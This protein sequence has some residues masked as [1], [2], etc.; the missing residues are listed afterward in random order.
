MFNSIQGFQLSPQQ[1]RL[2][3]LQGN[4]PAYHAHCAILIEGNLNI[5][6]LKEGLQ[7]V[8]DRHEILRTSFQRP[9]GIKIP[10][11][12]IEDSVSVSLNEQNNI[13]EQDVDQLFQKVSQY[14]LDLEEP[15]LLKTTL[16]RLFPNQYVLLLSLPALCADTIALDHLVAEIARCYTFCAEGETLDDEPLQYADI[17]QWQN[18][19]LEIEQAEA[20][21]EYWQQQNFSRGKTLK[22]ASEK[23]SAEK[24]EFEP[25]SITVAI[26]SNVTEKIEAIAQSN[27]TTASAFFL[28]CWQILLGR[29]TAQADL[30]I[31]VGFDGR[32]YEELQD[33]IGLF[34]KYLPL[35]VHLAADFPFVQVLQQV[36]PS[37]Y[38]LS[39]WQDSYTWESISESNVQDEEPPFFPFCFDFEPEFGSYRAGEVC[40]SVYRKYACVDQ[41]K[42]KLRTVRRESSWIAEFHYDSNSFAR[43]DIQR[44]AA[45]FQTLLVSAS[46]NPDAAIGEL[47]ILSLKERQQ[48]LVAF[49]TTTA[50][51]P[52]DK[53]LH[54]LFEAQVERTPNAIAVVFE[55]Q[56]LTYRE[57]NTKANQLAHHLQKLGVGA[58]V[59]VGICVER[60][61]EMVIGLLGILKAGG[62]YVP[63]E[64]T[65]P[66]QRQTF[67]LADTKIPVLLTQQRFVADLPTQQTTAI[68][69]DTDWQLIGKEPINDPIS[70]TTTHNLAYVIYTSGSTGQPKGTMITHQ[71]VVNYLSWCTQAYAVE[72]GTG[73][74]V[75]SPL[76]F[77]LTVT[78][79]FSSLLVGRSVELLPA[80]QGLETLASA[81]RRRT[82]LSLVKITPA[83][84]ELLSQQLS[85]QEAAG[86]T[87]AFIIGGENLLARHI[88]FWQQH[89]PNTLLVNE[90]GPTETVVGCCVYYVPA[91]Q[92][93]SGSIPIGRAIANTQLYVLDRYGQPVP[94]GVT[95]ELYIGGAGLA[96][97]Y[98]NRPELT[99]EKF[100]PNPFSQQLGDRLYRT[101]DLARYRP[102]GTLEYLGRI[103]D[104]VKIRG[105][106]IEL[107]EVEAVL[108][109]VPGVRE[110][111]VM[112]REDIPGHQR[113]V[114]YLVWNQESSTSLSELRDFLRQKLPEYMLPSAFV[115]LDTLPL[116][117]NGKVDRK[118]LPAPDKERPNL[119][120]AYVAPRTPIEQV[121]AEIWIQVLGLEQVGVHDNFLEVG[122]DSILSI[123]VISRA[124]QAGLHLTPQQLFDYPTIAELATVAGTAATISSEQG[125]VIGSVP[126]TPIQHWFFEQ[127]L[128]DS[129]HWNQ[130]VLLEVS[131]T[132]NPEQLQK[133]VEHLLKHHDSLRLRFK[134][135]TGGWQQINSSP[136]GQ[137]PFTHLDLSARSLQEQQSA[138]AAT[139]AELQARLNLSEG[140]LLRVAWFNLGLHQPS[141][142][143]L[144]IHHLA[145]DGVSWR[146]LL[147]DFQTAYQHLSQGKPIQLPPKTTA[148]KQW[149]EQLREYANSDT[150]RQE[151]NY[152]LTIA[153]QPVKRLPIDFP[154]GA[155]TVATRRTTTF[156]LSATDTQAL[157]QEIPAAYRVQ[158]HEVLLT[159]LV[160]TFTQW[161]GTRSALLPRGDAKGE[162]SSASLSLLIDLE[163]HGREAIFD[164]VDLSRTVG[165]FTTIFPV[166]LDLGQTSNLGDVLRIIKEQLRCIP[167]RGLGYGVLRYLCSDQGISQK[168]QDLPQAE[169]SFN[170]LGQF[171]QLLSTA[172]LFRPAKESIDSTRSQRGNR[173][174]LIEVEGMV[175]GGQ[176]RLDWTY[177]QTLHH[178]DTVESLAQRMEAALRSLITQGQSGE[179]D[180]YTPSDFPDA[181]LTQAELDKV[182]EEI[183]LD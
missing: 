90:Y 164:H 124:K 4:S 11:Q 145:I 134:R 182:F 122:G 160:Q 30:I 49:N 27:Q 158:I 98:L 51:Y 64:P 20:G 141:R 180:R 114:A 15:P 157:L 45:Q 80:N 47:E 46:D 173:R 62:A 56:Q 125:L 99:A 154:G 58:E 171:D 153:E 28:T 32:N 57:L 139:T 10:I 118:V 181:E 117:L 156:T 91:D 40:F 130:A 63:I 22:L 96:R 75:H 69:L 178:P 143:L 52:K 137:V 147:E 84:L 162:R 161:M 131:Q 83:H 140:P 151:L 34:A 26:E 23:Q 31:G 108:S 149:A 60:S 25:Q 42:V 37:L 16:V 107:G 54:Q 120:S 81:L 7:Q 94:I 148:F 166:F 169:V 179:V 55:D 70:Q 144:I 24:F 123:Q 100:I 152:W 93:S 165:W 183:G 115:S 121:L 53:C 36:E 92:G 138:I 163:G 177:S 65:Y 17:A 5:A 19:L 135:S 109:Q 71:G 129:H 38:E 103:D 116:T 146:I 155:N 21:E 78:S 13:R 33:A 136:D 50:D 82:N 110:S 1:K 74:L 97:G 76:G 35:P 41:F 105:F 29:L 67:I 66:L 2:F 61:L 73:T 72:E 127:N 132:L 85:P 126:L 88:T 106:R 170:Y 133:V 18:K 168:L 12:V 79:L 87:R 112:M 111:V 174:Y 104:Q 89:A 77:D 102:D 159:S 128:P 68:C 172:S 43:E 44:L 167:N 48:L 3:S 150:V 14:A 142:L 176:L 113:L 86:R 39:Q 8:V 175:V 101:G 119:E 6:V 9:R 59:L 95:G